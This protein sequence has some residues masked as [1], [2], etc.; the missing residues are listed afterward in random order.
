MNGIACLT[1]LTDRR[2]HNVLRALSAHGSFLP[3]RPSGDSLRFV[4]N[5]LRSSLHCGPCVGRL[6]GPGLAGH[7]VPRSPVRRRPHFVRLPPTRHFIPTGFLISFGRQYSS[8][9]AIQLDLVESIT[10]SYSKIFHRFSLGVWFNNPPLIFVK[11]I[12]LLSHLL[13]ER[14][15]PVNVEDTTDAG[16]GEALGGD[17]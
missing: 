3:V 2:N 16:F 9:R 5:P 10:S 8:S 13:Q 1:I 11:P 15:G 4:A 17:P 7:F 6:P 12:E 14:L